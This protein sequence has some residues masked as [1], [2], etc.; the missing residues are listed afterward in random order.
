MGFPITPFIDLL[1]SI[2]CFFCAWKLYSS[3][4][5]DRSNK[6]IEYFFK[7]YVMMMVAYLFFCLP[8]III[9]ENSFYLGV[10]FVIAQIFMFIA[11]AYLAM[12]TTFFADPSK[13]KIAFILV[14]ILA[15]VVFILSII[16]FGL[17]DYNTATGITNWNIDPIVGIA[18]SILFLM[19]LVPST[20]FFIIQGFKTHDNVVRVRSFLI[21][22]GFVLLII[23]A[24]TFYR[25]AT[26][27]QAFI[28]DLFSLSS[29][30]VIFLGVYYKRIYIFKNK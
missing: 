29:F 16:Y 23:T 27:T 10:G 18:S 21:S 22:L 4:K 28:S 14:I 30:I 26:Q 8:R 2:L 11:T 1:N 20:I 6:V 13:A 17:P 15:T 3:Y 12:I 5:R 25:A 19:V 7:A 24:Y 9:P